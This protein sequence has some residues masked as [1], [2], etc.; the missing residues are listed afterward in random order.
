MKGSFDSP[1]AVLNH[2]LTAT[3]LEQSGNNKSFNAD[4]FGL[5]SISFFIGFV[6]LWVYQDLFVSSP[7]RLGEVKQ[8]GIYQSPM[9]GEHASSLTTNLDESSHHCVFPRQWGNRA[10]RNGKVALKP[11]GA[12]TL[13]F[14]H[15]SLW[16]EWKHVRHR[17]KYLTDLSLGCGAFRGCS[18]AGGSVILRTGFECFLPLSLTGF[19]FLLPVCG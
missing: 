17:L 2:W 8:K 14:A 4:R 15:G 13:S 5:K 19:L 9:R 7:Q 6:S 10:W 12:K 18:I 16:F 11:S 3:V 1:K